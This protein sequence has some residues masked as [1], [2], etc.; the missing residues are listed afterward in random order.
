MIM[1]MLS[2]SM[3]MMVII[4]T[5]CLQGGWVENM[6]DALELMSTHFVYMYLYFI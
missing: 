3:M 2:K 4:I 5:T 6:G 1:I